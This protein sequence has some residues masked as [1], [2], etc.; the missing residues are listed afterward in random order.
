MRLHL[1]IKMTFLQKFL[2]LKYKPGLPRFAHNDTKEGFHLFYLHPTKNKTGWIF[3]E[4]RNT[5]PVVCG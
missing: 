1:N 4:V 2:L 3:R 5:Q